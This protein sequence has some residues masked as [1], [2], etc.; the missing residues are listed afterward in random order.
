[1]SGAERLHELAALAAAGAA[2]A[3]EE[4]ELEALVAGDPQA[5]REVTGYR[6]AAALLAGELTEV[7][8][9]P[10]GR[11]RLLQSIDAAPA[12]ARGQDVVDLASRRRRSAAAVVVAGLA[13]A[14]AI[15]L[16]ILWTRE[17]AE[18]G[19]LRQQLAE[20]AQQ[21]AETAQAQRQR[22]DLLASELSAAR[23][24]AAFVDS[25]SL[26]MATLGE[27]SGPT[28]KI[29]IDPAGERWLVLAY[30]LPP[31]GPG[32]DY[33]L[34][35][36][37]DG[38][39]AAPVPVGILRPGPTGALEAEVELPIDLEQIRAAAI[40]LEKAGG[41]QVPTDVKMIGPV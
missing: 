32:R 10:G 7:T 8:P 20:T 28:V 2:T 27:D 12:A 31:A 39:G 18:V 15:V 29:F 24:R 37:P 23:R 30:D 22:A 11:E 40:S 1:M 36:V 38:E 17:Q 35:A 26:R 16:A 6:E 9:P 41:V 14:A 34:W 25:P 4:R 3:Q 33:Q 21:A 5:A 13:A 19:R